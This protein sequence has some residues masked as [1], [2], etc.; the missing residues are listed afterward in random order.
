MCVSSDGL[1]ETAHLRS[2]TKVF[3]ARICDRKQI[4]MNMLLYILRDMSDIPF[5]ILLIS[6]V[7]H[8]M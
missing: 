6:Q 8:M 5:D 3:A 4:L 2:L 7:N 1:G